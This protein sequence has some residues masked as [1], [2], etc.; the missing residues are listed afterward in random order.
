MS[1]GTFLA[2]DPSHLLDYSPLYDMS[3]L[4]DWIGNPVVTYRYDNISH[5]DP[6]PFHADEP[7][8][9]GVCE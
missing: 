9:T 1:G 7:D 6:D 3:E 5:D 2:D 4:R 8:M